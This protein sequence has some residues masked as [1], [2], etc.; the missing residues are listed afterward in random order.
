MT[1]RYHRP[2]RVG[3][4]GSPLALAQARQVARQLRERSGRAAVLVAMA[5]LSTGSG[6]WPRCRI[7]G[8]RVMLAKAEPAC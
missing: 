2:L 1:S 7:T 3:T 6:R 8:R 4:R 5:T